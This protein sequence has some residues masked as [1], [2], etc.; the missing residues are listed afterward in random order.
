[1]IGT[2]IKIEILKEVIQK[3]NLFKSKEIVDYIAQCVK[4]GRF[5]FELRNN[6][7]IKFLTWEEQNQNGKLYIFISNLWVEPKYRN[8]NS[9]NMI[10]GKLK[11]IYKNARF[12][13]FDR[14]KQ[15]LIERI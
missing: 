3:N 9:L 10:R 12:I 8:K 14:K 11:G 7:V 1:M 13:W 6:E 2:L 4:E 15:K 5:L